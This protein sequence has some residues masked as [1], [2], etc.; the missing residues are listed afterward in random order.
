[1]LLNIRLAHLSI[2][3]VGCAHRQIHNL[4]GRVS[5]LA[6]IRPAWAADIRRRTF[7]IF[8]RSRIRW[9]EGIIQNG[10][11]LRQQAPRT[12]VAGHVGGEQQL[13]AEIGKLAR[14]LMV[15]GRPSRRTG[16]HR[17]DQNSVT[18]MVVLRWC[19]WCSRRRRYGK[20]KAPNDA[21]FGR[22]D[23]PPP[24]QQ[25]RLSRR[26]VPVLGLWPLHLEG[27]PS[28]DK[29]D[30]CNRAVKIILEK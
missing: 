3:C 19:C 27:F 16:Q 6:R 1:M 18:V 14:Q 23:L 30:H 8:T 29:K 2:F 7:L 28:T 15:V 13:V 25:H 17:Q 24:Q 4:C 20:R 9:R 11:I 22:L 12:N 26:A 5:T 10:S 21:V